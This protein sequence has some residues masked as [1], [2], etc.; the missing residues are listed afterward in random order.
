MRKSDLVTRIEAKIYEMIGQ[1]ARVFWNLE[2]ETMLMVELPAV[3]SD[4][5]VAPVI[6]GAVA[7][8]LEEI[9]VYSVVTGVGISVGDSM[10]ILIGLTVSLVPPPSEMEAN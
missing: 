2:D 4:L 9:E 5:L 7:L 1:P 8:S 10:A 3:E 6:A